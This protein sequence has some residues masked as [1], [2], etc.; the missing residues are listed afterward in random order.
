MIYVALKLRRLISFF[1]LLRFSCSRFS[2]FPALV[3]C[4]RLL[5]QSATSST[6]VTLAEGHKIKAAFL[7]QV[8]R[9]ISNELA[10]F[11]RSAHMRLCADRDYCMT[12]HWTVRRMCA[13]VPPNRQGPIILVV[14]ASTWHKP[15]KPQPPHLSLH[16]RPASVPRIDATPQ[17]LSSF[18]F[19]HSF[20]AAGWACKRPP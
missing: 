4:K 5:E 19:S 7:L 14:P 11:V 2:S 20:V 10:K 8:R 9:V 17:N 1:R 3:A 13:W 16:L 15:S 6:A 12:S 18:P